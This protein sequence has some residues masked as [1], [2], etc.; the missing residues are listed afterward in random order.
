MTT[1]IHTSN[2]DDTQGHVMS[3]EPFVLRCSKVIIG[4]GQIL[5]NAAIGVRNGIIEYI[6]SDAEIPRGVPVRDTGS[7][8]VMPAII[9]PHGH[10]GYLKQGVC[11]AENFSR[12]N[13]LDHLQRLAYYG[14][15]VFQSLGTDRGDTEVKIRNDQATGSL[16]TKT[17]AAL[18]TA[19]NGIAAPTPG[20]SNAGASFASDVIRDVASPEQARLAVADIAQRRPDSIKFWIDNRSGTR[21][22]PDAATAAAIVDESHRHGIRVIAHIHSAEDA[23]KALR[24]GVDGLAHMVRGGLDE[25]LVAALRQNDVFVFS[26][27]AIQRNFVEDTSWLDEPWASETVSE[28]AKEDLRREFKGYDASFM[29]EMASEYAFLKEQVAALTSSGVRVLL[30]AD[31]GLGGQFF[32]V[33]EHRELE[34]L[35]LLGMSNAEAIE[36]ATALPAAMLGLLDRG[37]LEPGKRADF[38]VLDGDPIVDIAQTRSIR[39]VYLGGERLDRES[40]RNAWANESIETD[41]TKTAVISVA[42]GGCR[43]PRGL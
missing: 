22:V 18:L 4:N 17:M 41:R 2:S 39:D 7:A 14:V 23:W 27:T 35:T 19:S 32:G 5:G 43:T 28:A 10:I 13:V 24:A 36:A 31:T 33:A 3:D 38:L 29:A 37:T 1:H 15:S 30:S 25:D 9:N 20:C 16:S 42:G 11:S 6:A 40:L 8:V 12:E 21:L 26:S 34:T